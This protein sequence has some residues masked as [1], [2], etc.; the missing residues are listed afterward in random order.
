M[1]VFAVFAVTFRRL[2]VSSLS[3][4]TLSRLLP[5]DLNKS[6]I[7]MT[8]VNESKPSE[9]TGFSSVRTALSGN[10]Q[11]PGGNEQLGDVYVE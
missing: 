5:S 8:T 10:L 1:H 3:I 9:S 2:T 7:S 4:F 11:Q 6:G